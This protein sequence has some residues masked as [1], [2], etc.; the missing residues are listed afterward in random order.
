[1]HL[2]ASW[3]SILRSLALDQMGIAEL[4]GSTFRSR[5][6][7]RCPGLPAHQGLTCRCFI[8][9]E[10]NVMSFQSQGCLGA[11]AELRKLL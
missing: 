3:P 2:G 5:P 7:A 11:W 8:T 10:Q 9:M 1:M 4:I 6:R